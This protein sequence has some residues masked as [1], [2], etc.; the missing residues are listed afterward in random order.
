MID[1]F[2]KKDRD[3]AIVKMIARRH[4]FPANLDPRSLYQISTEK[5]R[6]VLV[7]YNA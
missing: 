1:F 7:C 2:Q 5:E 4:S 3:I 6:D